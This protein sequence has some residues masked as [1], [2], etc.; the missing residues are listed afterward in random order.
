[1]KKTQVLITEEREFDFRR[2]VNDYLGRGFLMVPESL[3]CATSSGHTLY[4]VIMEK[5]D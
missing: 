1:M 4:A 3:R 2:E 5:N